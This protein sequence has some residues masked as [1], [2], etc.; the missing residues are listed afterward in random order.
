[1]SSPADALTLV[2][3]FPSFAL[4]PRME[5]VASAEVPPPYRDLLVHNHHMTVTVEAFHHDRVNVRIL[6]RSQTDDCYARRILL[7]K[8][9]DDTVVQFGIAR[10]RLQYCSEPVRGAILEGKTPL[11]RI[12]IENNVLREIVPMAFLRVMPGP[13]IAEWFGPQL[14]LVVTYG[15]LGAIHCD[16]KPAIE[17]LEIVAPI[18]PGA[19]P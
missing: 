10:I 4:R 16:E 14:G 7:T 1:M 3:L 9:S 5:L 15:R 2:D 13:A 6:E 18:P 12:L 17:V 19:T 11:G 8:Q